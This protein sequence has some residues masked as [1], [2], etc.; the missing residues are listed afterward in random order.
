MGYSVG[1]KIADEARLYTLGGMQC[2]ESL[3]GNL[4]V[5]ICWIS[6][7]WSDVLGFGSNV[8]VFGRVVLGWDMGNNG[9]D[10]YF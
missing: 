4:R 5:S 2:S 10:K 1:L 9:M 6:F 8:F 7:D 3:L